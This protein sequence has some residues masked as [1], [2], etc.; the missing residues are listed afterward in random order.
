MSGVQ[1][2]VFRG[3]QS[4]AAQ[5]KADLKKV[6]GERDG[7]QTKVDECNADDGTRA[8]TTRAQRITYVMN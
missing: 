8:Y 7:L 5:A 4:D 2:L 1:W 3:E 6:T